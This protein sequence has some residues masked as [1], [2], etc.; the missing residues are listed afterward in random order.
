MS[1]QLNPAGMLLS[2]GKIIVPLLQSV[3]KPVVTTKIISKKIQQLGG[4]VSEWVKLCSSGGQLF[5]KHIISSMTTQKPWLVLWVIN[6][7]APHCITTFTL[8]FGKENRILQDAC[9]FKG[10]G[11]LPQKL[12]E[13]VAY[14]HMFLLFCYLVMNS[15]ST[16]HQSHTDKTITCRSFPFHQEAGKLVQGAWESLRKQEGILP[17]CQLQWAPHAILLTVVA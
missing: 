14:W 17:G 8:D 10:N 9:L 7:K 13:S 6:F 11:I 16:S 4:K 12:F 5:R 2:N 3:R 15:H 1:V